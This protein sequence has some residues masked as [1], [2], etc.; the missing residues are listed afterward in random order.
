MKKQLLLLVMM[1]LPMMAM[2]I[3][4]K[5]D[6]LWYELV[7]KTKEAKVIK[8][9][10]NIYYGGDIIIPETVLYDGETYS[11]ISIG[12]AAFYKCYNLIS[13]ILPNSIT[14]IEDG[15]YYD[16]AF[17]EC[18]N[19]KSITLPNS[20][21]TIG[22]WAFFGCNSLKEIII[23]NSVKNLGVQSFRR[24][25]GIVSIT[26]PN[27][28]TSIAPFVF[29]ECTSLT[30]AKLPDNVSTVEDGLFYGCSKLTSITIPP[31]VT[32]I[33]NQA[34]YGC[35]KLTTVTIPNNVTD[36]GKYAF[37]GCGIINLTIPNSTT[38]IGEFSYY[39]CKSLSTVTIG[40]GAKKIDSQAFANCSDLTDVFCLAL[41]LP[42]TAT[43]AFEGS[44][45][46]YATLHVPDVSV[47]AYC[48]AEPWM[49][50]KEIVGMNGTIPGTQKCA[51]PTIQIV[52]GKLKLSCETEGVTF[53]TSYTSEGLSNS[54]LDDEIVLAGTTTCHVSVYVTKEGYENSDVAEADVELYVGLK[55]DVNAD[56][57]VNVGDIVTTTN[58]MAGKDE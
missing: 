33:G 43:D 14:E 11:V 53:V 45:I 5:I 44:L 52:G 50:F 7:S 39:G 51:T 12:S 3:E 55:G 47:I 24:C 10:D 41:E 1:L 58:I 20:L 25:T 26:I 27:N 54:T 16:G 31:T 38:S 17:Y 37:Y 6:G 35:E 36:I 42:N 8:Y 28:V 13:I 2:A 15:E 49:N 18:V 57:E 9:K 46:E 4:V 23:P 40:T 34:F 21:T 29:E 30:T 48:Q 56:G 19:L 22:K 32:K